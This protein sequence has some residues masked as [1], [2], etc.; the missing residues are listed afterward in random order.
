L[1][2]RPSTRLNNGIKLINS[3]LI[4]TLRVNQASKITKICKSVAG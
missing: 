3:R 4:Q 2:T 1:R